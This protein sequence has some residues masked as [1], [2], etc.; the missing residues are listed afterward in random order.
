MRMAMEIP[1]R[2]FRGNGLGDKMLALAVLPILVLGIVLMVVS[3]QTF[4]DK[5]EG[6]VRKEMTQQTKLILKIL[7]ENYPGEFSLNKDV[8]G[9]YH[10]YKGGKDITKDTEFIDNMKEIMGVEVTLFCQD[11]RLQTTLRDSKGRLFINTAVSSVITKDVL[12]KKKAH[13]YRSTTNVGDERYFAYYEPIFLEDGTCF[14]MV[15]VCRKATDIEKNIRMAV[16]PILLLSIAAIFVIGAISISY[17]RILTK[18]IRIL[19]QFMKKLTKDD[20]EAEMPAGLLKVEDEIG[21]L[22]RSGKK[23]QE[24]IRRQVEYD[25]MT[26]LYNRRYGDKNLLKMKAQMQISGIKYCVAIGD[27]DFFKKVND[28]YGHEAGDEVLIHVARVL[29]EQLLANGFVCRWG[30]EEFL[31]VIESHTIEQ[32]EHIL[33]S[34]LDTL[35]NQTIT[36]QEQQIR[37]TMSMGLVSVKAEDEIDDILRCADQKLYEAKENGRDQIRC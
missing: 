10:I 17:T 13:F 36:Y 24:S 3:M 22:A 26:Q 7:D 35:R 27:I 14:G 19:Q 29:K 9:N 25:E 31:I 23:M 16:R 4:S 1:K 12:K 32:A 15:G 34:I 28:N 37:V 5:M 18:R 20:F 8:K 33:Q 21:D 30:G 11:V 2:E 6:H